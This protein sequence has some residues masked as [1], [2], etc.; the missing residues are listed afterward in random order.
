MHAPSHQCLTQALRTASG[1]SGFLLVETNTTFR[2][3]VNAQGITQPACTL[4][5][6]CNTGCARS[7]RTF[8]YSLLSRI[9]PSSL[10]SAVQ[11]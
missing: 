3:R 11:L 1:G 9:T 10:P 8:A 2:E 7:N 4:C 5:G 6:D